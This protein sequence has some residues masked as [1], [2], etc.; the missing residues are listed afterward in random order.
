MQRREITA[1]LHAG[2]ERLETAA[3]AENERILIVG[4]L[5]R[6]FVMDDREWREASAPGWIFLPQ[7][8][9]QELR[10]RVRRVWTRPLNAVELLESRVG[11][12]RQLRR[13]RA[14]FIP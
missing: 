5:D 8:C 11:H 3:G 2:V 12:P 1:S 4:L 14:H 6:S 13:Q 9:V 7:S 10:S